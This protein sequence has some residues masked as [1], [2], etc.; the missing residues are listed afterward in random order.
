LGAPGATSP[1]VGEIQRSIAAHP[2]LTDNLLRVLNHDLPPAKLV[3]PALALGATAKAWTNSPG[4]RA[5]VLGEARALINRQLHRRYP[6]RLHHRGTTE[7]AQQSAQG[8][9]EKQWA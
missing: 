3:T 7:A 5:A 4:H 2:G 9:R 8:D 6:P 1:I